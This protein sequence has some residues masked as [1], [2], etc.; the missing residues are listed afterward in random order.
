MKLLGFKISPE[1]DLLAL[2]WL[3][4]FAVVYLGMVH[5]GEYRGPFLEF[6]PTYL[7]S[8]AGP[9]WSELLNPMVFESY[10]HHLWFLGFL[11]VYSLIA[12]P[13]FLWLKKEAG[14]RIVIRLGSLAEVRGSTL[15]PLIPLVL[16]RLLLQPLYPGHT[17]WADFFFMLLFF[18]YGYVLYADERFTRAIRRDWAL[19]LVLAIACT[20]VGYSCYLAGLAETWAYSPGT[21]GFYLIWSVLSTVSWCW[22]TTILYASMRFLDFRNKWLEYGQDAVMP[23]YVFHHPAI[24]AIA[25]YVVRWDTAA[26]LPSTTIWTDGAAGDILVKLLVVALSSFVASIGLY[27]LC[28]RRFGVAR[29]LFGMKPPRRQ[30]TEMDAE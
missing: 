21:M 23:F 30:A 10:G 4:R 17:D 20:V 29:A 15:V 26:W 3:L 16:V 7:A 13:I 1:S 19:V 14:Q 28:V 9:S 5:K 8:R 22:V 11:F 2:K 25:F 27:E 24:I 12:L 6:G 18:I